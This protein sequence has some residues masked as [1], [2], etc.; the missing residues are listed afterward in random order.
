MTEEINDYFNKGL[1]LHTFQAERNIH[2][3]KYIAGEF[4]FL[5]TQKKEIIEMYEFIQRSAQTNYIL[6]LGKIFDNP[7]RIH[8]N[9]CIQTFLYKLLESANVQIIETT[10]TVKLLKKY[11][12]SSELIESVENSQKNSFPE[13]FAKYYL[14]KYNDNDFQIEINKLKSLR[15]KVEAHNEVIGNLSLEFDTTERLL[16]FVTEI[17]TIFGMAYYSTIW[18]PLVKTNAEDYSFFIKSNIADLKKH[19]IYIPRPLGYTPPS[20][21]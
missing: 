13:L 20:R 11:M 3:W 10:E 9:R 1:I 7:N 21:I 18:G 15:N 2:I 6:S 12:C 17:I 14:K 8:P 5:N 19:K 16:D 4:D